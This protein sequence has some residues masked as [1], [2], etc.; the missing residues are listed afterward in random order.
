MISGYTMVSNAVS[1]DYCID[2]CVRSLSAFCDEVVVGY[3][4]SHDDTPNVLQHLV[5]TLPNVRI[6]HAPADFSVNGGGIDWMLD[7]MDSVRKQ[8]NGDYQVQLDADEVI[9]EWC[10][11]DIL[12]AARAGESL[13]CNRLNF[14]G[15]LNRIA[16]HGHFCGHLVPRCAP[17]KYSLP[18]DFPVTTE[19]CPV[20]L[21][22]RPSRVQ[23]FH[24]CTLR[25]PEAF[26]KKSRAFQPVLL[27]AYDTR[28]DEAMDNPVHWSDHFQ[29][30]HPFIEYNGP[31]PE[32][33]KPWLRE[34][35]YDV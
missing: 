20:I 35:H 10:I 21:K 15:K 4:P 5:D 17:V 26:L 28:I 34:R 7:W 19:R 18:S 6:V 32:V 25:K 13:L 31:H 22:A 24:Y 23:V 3:S 8:L 12:K 1:Q 14:W 9:P 2:P 16:P 27:G 30:P 33:V 29:F 11:D